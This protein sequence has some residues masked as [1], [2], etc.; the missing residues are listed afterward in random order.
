M[1]SGTPDSYTTAIDTAAHHKG[2][3]MLMSV[4]KYPQTPCSIV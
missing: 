2:K 4:A 1:N 3:A